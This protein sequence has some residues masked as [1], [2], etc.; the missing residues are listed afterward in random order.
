MEQLQIS[1]IAVESAERFTKRI[2]FNNPQVLVFTLTFRPGQTLPAHRHPRS[3]AVLQVFSGAGQVT[4]D[5]RESPITQGE[6][7]LVT[8]EEELGISNTSE[9]ALTVLV[10]LSPNPNNPVYTKEER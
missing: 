9:A 8:S 3:A 10:T 4:I 5:G 1:E 6:L 7:L 2:C